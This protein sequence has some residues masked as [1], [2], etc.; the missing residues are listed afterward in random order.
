MKI[1]FFGTPKFA[2]KNLEYLIQKGHNIVAVISNFDTKKG[3]GRQHTASEVKKTA[4]S[5]NLPLIQPQNLKDPLFIEKLKSYNAD[6]FIVVAFRVL[7]KKVWGIPKKG[8]INLHTSYLPNYRGAAPINRVLINNEKETGITT[9]FINEKIDSG[10]II[11]QEK[12]ALSNNTTA[13]QLHELLINKG[14]KLLTNTIKSINDNNMILI[15]QSEESTMKSAPKITKEMLRIDWNKSA[16]EIHH[17]VRG[18]SPYLENN[19]LLKN[20]EIFPSAWFILK[21]ENGNEKRIKL[22]LTEINN[23]IKNKENL[24]I[25]TDNKSFLNIY[26]KNKYLSVLHLQAEGKKP[27][28]IK[29]F[30]QGNKISPKCKIL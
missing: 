3:R 15:P 5:N 1:I 8:T 21:T 27:M 17:L 7:P 6:L 11:M 12:C 28:T 20:I 2:A 13:A 23:T 10:T 25:E 29:Q 9:F 19:L 24:S 14:N 26:I 18:V 4:L 16:D 30:L 22:Q